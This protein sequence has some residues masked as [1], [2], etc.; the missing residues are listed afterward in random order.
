MSS[1]GFNKTEII[2]TALTLVV[3]LVAIIFN[4]RISLRRERDFQRKNDLQSIVKALEAFHVDTAS[5]PQSFE[6]KIVACH[7]GIDE[8]GTPQPVACGWYGDSLTNIFTGT[9]FLERL[10]TDPKHNQGARYYYIS[11]GRYFQ[12]YAALEGT[13]EA[14]YDEQIVSRNIFCGTS[15]CNYGKSFAGAPLDKSIEEYENEL[16]MQGKL[17]EN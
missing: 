1:F 12:I 10:P 4:F 16:R 8:A 6:G 14:E 2:A 9:V 3:I 5:F 17:N 7:G 13:D 11:N 15:V